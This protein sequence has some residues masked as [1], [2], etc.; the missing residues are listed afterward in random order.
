MNTNNLVGLMS[1]ARYKTYYFRDYDLHRK[2]ISEIM[3]KNPKILDNKRERLF[4]V[5]HSNK[6]KAN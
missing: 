1:Q 4:N 3:N 5:Y 6:G 2:K